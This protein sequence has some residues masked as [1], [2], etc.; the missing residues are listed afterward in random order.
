MPRLLRPSTYR[1]RALRRA[2][3]PAERALWE[4]L[5]DR[6]LGYKFRRQHPIGPFVA[7]FFCRAAN[8]V[9]EVDGPYHDARRAYD[10]Q[11]D[12]W[13]RAAGLR[14]LRLANELVLHHP[15]RALQRIRR[16]LPPG[17]APFSRR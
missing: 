16:S 15:E 13:L 10:R 3:T 8:L 14:I 12:D 7:D 17:P 6:G 9:V 11:R 4:L 5:R 1:A 2:M